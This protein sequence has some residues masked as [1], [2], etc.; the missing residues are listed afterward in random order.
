MHKAGLAV[1]VMLLASCEGGDAGDRTG[2]NADASAPASN[3][4]DIGAVSMNEPAAEPAEAA[5]A[6]KG[7][8]SPCLMQG[9]GRLQVAPMRAVGTE[10]F[11]SARV[12]G[13][14]VTYS[15][16]EDQKGVRVWTRYSAAPG[17]GGVWAGELDGRKFEMRT[18][19]EAGCSDGMSDQSYSMAVDLLVNGEQRRGCAELL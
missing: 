15:T 7:T 11:W 3:E 12:E 14:C 5:D 19:A 9:D 13:R 18:R 10:P 8:V 17:G 6:G 4:T 2:S 16:P 1:A